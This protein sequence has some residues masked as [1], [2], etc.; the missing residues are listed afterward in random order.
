MNHRSRNFVAEDPRIRDERIEPAKGIQIAAAEPDHPDLQ[1][2]V[3]IRYDWIR[4]LLDGCVSRVVQYESL[5][6]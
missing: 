1:Q 2:H 6:D 5:H 3:S 4:N